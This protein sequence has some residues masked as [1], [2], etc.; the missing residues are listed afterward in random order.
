MWFEPAGQA[1]TAVAVFTACTA[2]RNEQSPSVLSSSA[3]VVTL[4]G[5]AAD[6]GAAPLH[7]IA[8]IAASRMSTATGP[9]MRC[10]SAMTPPPGVASARIIGPRPAQ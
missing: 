3:V 6:A 1:S 2:S 8:L 7:E 4:I 10:R 9:M 5:V